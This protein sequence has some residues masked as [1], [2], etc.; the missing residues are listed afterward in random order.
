MPFKTCLYLKLCEY[1]KVM[2]WSDIL[3]PKRLVWLRGQI[4]AVLK[5][6]YIVYYLRFYNKELKWNLSKA[7]PM[8]KYFWS[9][10]HIRNNKAFTFFIT[11]KWKGLHAQCCE[12]NGKENSLILAGWF[13]DEQ[14]NC[15]GFH[16]YH[17]SPLSI[18]EFIYSIGRCYGRAFRGP[19]D[20]CTVCKYTV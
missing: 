18:I 4:T 15:V 1:N 8:E 5:K 20:L 2:C 17:D 16:Q 9:Y 7:H 10:C 19:G 11:F 6:R 12:V 13:T 14:W 3:S